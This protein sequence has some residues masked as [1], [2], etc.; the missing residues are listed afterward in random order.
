MD[1]KVPDDLWD[2]DSEGV[3]TVWFANDGETINAN[4]LLLEI[5]T[6][7]VQYEILA[8]TWGTVSIAVG[9]DTAVKKGTVVGHISHH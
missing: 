6:A 2:D 8:P 5:M 1:V 9:V 4:E 7:K 3:I